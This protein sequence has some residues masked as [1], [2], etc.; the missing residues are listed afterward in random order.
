[1]CHKSEQK[2]VSNITKL[3]TSMHKYNVHDPINEPY[4]RIVKFSKTSD[5]ENNIKLLKSLHEN[6][7]DTEIQ[8]TNDN[9]NC[10]FPHGISNTLREIKKIEENTLL[11]NAK[12]HLM[13]TF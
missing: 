9:L 2:Y 5:W 8:S 1:M 11:M 6:H 3:L 4:A 13:L 12:M 7:L 10:N